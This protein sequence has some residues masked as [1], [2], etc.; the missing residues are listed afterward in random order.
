MPYQTPEHQS[1]EKGERT[2]EEILEFDIKVHPQPL[3][4]L[5]DSEIRLFQD[6]LKEF[7][8]S[9]HNL[10]HT[11]QVVQAAS[12]VVEL[13]SG[14]GHWKPCKPWPDRPSRWF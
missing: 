10:S 14:E 5:A 9:R 3:V 11:Q 7:R 1:C 6:A 8:A 2:K 12:M 13:T 4:E